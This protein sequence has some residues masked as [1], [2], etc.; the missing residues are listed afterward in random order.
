[1][2]HPMSDTS[3][4]D[5]DPVSSLRAMTA[6]GPAAARPGAP[7][8]IL[9]VDDDAL[10]RASLAAVLDCEGYEVFGDADGQAAVDHA[11]EH[12][13]DLVLLD[14][15]MPHLDGWSTFIM[16]DNTHPLIPVIVITARP[17]QYPQ[18]V[19]LGVD[20]FM[21][22]P[23]NFPKLLDAIRRLTSESEEQHTRRISDPDF[24]TW[25]LASETPGVF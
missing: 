17:N 13:P 20:A 5:F 10:V 21:E 23:L 22:K 1:M 7:K 15:N 3:T 25:R 8:R 24:T 11:I 18:A 12:Q 14:L 19:E 6:A 4:A 2:T 9:I 16:L